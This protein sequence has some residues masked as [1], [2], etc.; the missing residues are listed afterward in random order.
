MTYFFDANLSTKLAQMLQALGVSVVHLQ[1]HFPKDAPDRQWIPWV[2][3]RGWV[4][5]TTDGRILQNPAERRALERAHIIA[6]FLFRG[7]SEMT[8]WA[9][10]CWLLRWWPR[11]TSAVHQAA[12]GTNLHINRMGRVSELD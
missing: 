3:K 12:P 4:I 6:V 5:V 10:A 2:G 11:I 8:R 7:F 9:Q 1:Q